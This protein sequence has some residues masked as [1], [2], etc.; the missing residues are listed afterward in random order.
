M[1]PFMQNSKICN[2]ICS[3]RREVSSNLGMEAA[4]RMDYK[5]E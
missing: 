2:P 3:K 4:G 1:I 5:V